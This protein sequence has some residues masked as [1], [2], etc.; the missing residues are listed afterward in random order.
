MLPL[1]GSAF[2][3]PGAAAAESRRLL[4]AVGGREEEEE[5]AGCRGRACSAAAL[6]WKSHGALMH[7]VVR[8][9]GHMPPRDTPLAARYMIERWLR[10]AVVEGPAAEGRSLGNG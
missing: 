6:Y 1:L 5:Q 8:A 7:V 3:D 4:L 9:A 10:E 2:A